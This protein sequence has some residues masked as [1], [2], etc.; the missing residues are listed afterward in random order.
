[1]RSVSVQVRYDENLVPKR[2]WERGC[3]GEGNGHVKKSIRLVWK[4]NNSA[5]ASRFFAHF[6]CRPNTTMTWN[7]QILSL[8]ED[9]NGQA[10]NSTISVWTRAQYTL[11]STNIN[12]LLSGAM[13]SCFFWVTGRPG[14]TVKGFERMWSLFS[15]DVFVDSG[16]KARGTI[17]KAKQRDYLFLFPSSTASLLFLFLIGTLLFS[18]PSIFFFFLLK[19]S[20]FYG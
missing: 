17:G 16:K 13:G 3:D 1:M 19:R 20:H 11:F 18:L 5:R 7:E 8:L 9:A 6:L 12:S 10:I 2:T 15:H 4:S 14:I